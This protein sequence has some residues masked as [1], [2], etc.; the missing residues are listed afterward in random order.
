MP[1]QRPRILYFKDYLPTPLCIALSMFF[2]MVF[3]F[4]GGVFLPTSLQ[5]SSALGCLKEDVMMAGY[6]SFIGMTLIFPILFRLKFR[7]TT[8][9]IFLTVCPVL[10][11]CNLITMSSQNILILV[12]TCF[13]SGFFRMWGTFECFSNIRLS[14]TPSGNFSVFYPVIYI[15]VLESIQLSGLVATHISDWANWQYMH[16]FVIGLLTVVWLCVLLFTRPF[17]IAKKMPLYGIDWIGGALWG[18][19]LFSIV[20]ICIYGEYCD[21]LDSP[22]IRRCIV[23]ATVATLININRMKTLR[24]PYIDPQVLKYRHFPT[25]L[26]LFLMLCLFLTTSSVLQEKFM[27]SILKYDMLNAVSLNWCVFVGIL[28]GA[29]VVFY[30]QVI[31]RKGYKLLITVGFILIVIYQYYM[32]FLIHPNL[33]IESLYFPN[34]LKGLGHG[35]LYISLTIYIAKTVPFKHFF[36]GLCVLSFIRTSIATPLGT[37]ILNRWL[38]YMQQEN[39]GLLSRK[40]DMV[41]E[42]MPNVSIQELYAQVTTQTLLTSLKELFGVVC[43]IGT[44]FLVVLVGQ[45]LWR[46]L[47]ALARMHLQK[48]F[49][50]IKNSNPPA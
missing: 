47:L 29:G 11:C 2:A 17:R 39:L 28:A 16:W 37:A 48:S 44:A 5:M 35:I 7:F 43:I 23:I 24:H 19:V 45:K 46:K 31:I 3:Q 30:R 20:F 10:I 27:S 8:R 50:V 6:A 9:R 41:K 40:M 15:I 38:K 4:N 49:H 25:I 34:F 18:V 13:I 36:Q 26:F 22:Y 1:E 12:I 14:V 33:N 21:W 32:Y 42:W